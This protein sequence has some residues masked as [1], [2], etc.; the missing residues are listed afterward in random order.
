MVGNIQPEVRQGLIAATLHMVNRGAP[1]AASPA[2][3][4]GRVRG[5]PA[6]RWLGLVSR[7]CSVQQADSP[8]SLG[9]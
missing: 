5:R 6:G 7:R 9:G 3:S 8:T 1:W 4:G 2:D